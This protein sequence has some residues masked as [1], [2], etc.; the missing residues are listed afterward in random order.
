MDDDKTRM[1]PESSLGTGESVWQLSACIG[2]P[3]AQRN[4]FHRDGA[5]H[6]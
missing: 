5:V 2:Q 6:R 3:W 4:G 1:V